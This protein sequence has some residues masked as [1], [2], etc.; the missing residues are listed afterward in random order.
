[1]ARIRVNK[2]KKPLLGLLSCLSD[3][4]LTQKSKLQ[5]ASRNLSG[6]IA[7]RRWITPGLPN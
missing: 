6:P 7:L 3:K 1:M 5:L 4:S 2:R